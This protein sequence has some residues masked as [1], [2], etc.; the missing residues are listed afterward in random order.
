MGALLVTLIPFPCAGGA[1]GNALPALGG[2]ASQLLPHGLPGQKRA[3]CDFTVKSHSARGELWNETGA[4]DY[5]PGTSP[6]SVSSQCKYPLD[7]QPLG[8]VQCVLSR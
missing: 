1:A 8:C 5:S 6:G 3:W 4:E 2:T 7:S